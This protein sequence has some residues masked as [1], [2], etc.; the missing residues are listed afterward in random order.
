MAAPLLHL[1]LALALASQ[2]E[3]DAAET[4]TTSDELPFTDA[5]LDYLERMRDQLREELSGGAPAPAA[6]A[7]APASAS[8]LELKAEAYIKWLYR[9]NTSQGCVTYGNPHPTGDNYSGDNGACPELALTL[10]ARPTPRI[11]GGFRLQSRYGMDFADWFENGDERDLP[12]ASAESYGLNHAAAIQLRGIYVRVAEPL[13]F[14]DWFLAGSSDLGFWDPWTV[15]R[16][17]FIDRFNAKGLF[18]KTSAGP[19]DLLI[20]RIA[21]AK[22]FGTANYNSIEE[23]LIT[24]PFWTRDAVYA[25][26]LSTRPSTI[27]GV[28]VTLNAAMSVDEE[29]DLRDPDA[30]G[31]TNTVDARDQVTAVDARFIGQNASLF[32]DVTR[33]DW[34]RARAL[35]AVSHNSPNLRYV[36][37]L[38][39]GGLGFSNVVYSDATDVAGTLRI[40]LPELLAKGMALRFE[41]FNIGADFNS[42][43]GS[44][45][46]EDV[47]LTDGFH[48]GG[49]LPTLNLAN[50]LIDFNDRFYESIIGWH[51]ATLVLDHASDL[52]DFA[53]EG[54]FIEYNTDLQDRDMDLYPGFGGF[55][56]YTDTDLFS[57]AN[58]NDRGRDPRAV[59]ARDQARRTVIAMGRAALKPSGL[60]AGA[61]LDVKAKL[62][63]DTDLRDETTELDDYAGTILTGNVSVGAQPLEAVNVAL[64]VK[65]D[66]WEEIGRSGTYAGGQPSFLDYTT[67]KVKPYVEG[68][69]SVGALS[70][71]YHL[72]VVKKDITTSDPTQDSSTGLIW[73]SVGFVSAQF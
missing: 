20:A 17:R 56:G 44:R 30:P 60:W 65:L 58:T 52:V 73:R 55:T 21:M 36:T 66:R 53:I 29:A 31:S 35:L 48:D 47:L 54:T 23:A 9:N 1:A 50:E 25:L 8:M 41:Y 28:M 49:Q 62:I 69:Y 42:I 61:R 10:T 18:L 63:R 37:N 24:N 64:G 6:G 38:A 14:V 40:E 32:V 34:M 72:E 43:A 46:E 71:S 15:G 68:R 22:L 57:Y 2:T 39:L 27:D 12:D 5:Q 45:R 7:T 67:T 16:V 19:I 51:G 11:E 3:V 70:A 26:S 33:W 4:S 59:Y 13:P